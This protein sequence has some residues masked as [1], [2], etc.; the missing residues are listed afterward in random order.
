M[1]GKVLKGNKKAGEMG[2]PTA[3]IKNT[4]N[5]L[6]GIYAGRASVDNKTYDAVIYVG[7]N[8]IDILEVH[9]FDFKDDLYDKDINV[10]ILE[11]IRDDRHVTDVNIL[12]E[13]IKKDCI[14]AKEI[15]KKIKCLQE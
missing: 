8:N 11:K 15:L 9:F 6:A 7:T 2:F 3:N 4:E 13:M 1:N 12:Q 10:E 14:D 5:V